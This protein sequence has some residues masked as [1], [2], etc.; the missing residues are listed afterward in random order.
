LFLLLLCIGRRV[1]HFDFAF[2]CV[3]M[4]VKWKWR[5]TSAF[6]SLVLFAVKMVFLIF[7]KYSV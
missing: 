4:R 2:V 5:K 6:C 7:K 1:G 3:I